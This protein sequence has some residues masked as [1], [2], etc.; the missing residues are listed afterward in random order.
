APY[1][2]GIRSGETDTTMTTNYYWLNNKSLY[3]GDNNRGYVYTIPAGHKKFILSIANVTR[4]DSNNVTS[5]Q[6]SISF[7]ELQAAGLEIWYSP[8]PEQT[9]P[10]PFNTGDKVKIDLSNAEWVNYGIKEYGTEPSY[11]PGLRIS[12]DIIFD[13]PYD[14]A[15]FYV[16]IN[17]PY[18]LGIRSGETDTAM[19]TNYY[20]LNNKYLVSGNHNRDYIYTIPAGHT[21]FILSIANVSRNVSGN[22]SSDE[23]ITLEELEAAGLEIW[24]VPCTHVYENGI[25]TGCGAEDPN[26]L[27]LDGLNVLCLGDSITAGQGLTTATRWTNVLAS[28]YDWTL[29][30]KSQGGISLSSYYYTSNGQTDVS[31][32]K[33]AEILKTMTVKPDV[34]IVWGGHNDISYRY[35]PLGTWNDETTDS[36]KGA[37]KYI[38]ELAHEYAPDATLFVLTPLWFNEKPYTL[39][40]PENTSDT[41]LMF[42]DAIYEGAEKYGWIPINMDLCGVTAF[43]KSDFLLDNVHPNAA[44]TELIVE[45]LSTELASYGENSKKDTIL[46]NKS[47]VSMKTGESTTLKGVLSPQSGYS[48]PAFTWNSSNPSVATIDANGKITA[49]AHGNTII[50]ATTSDGTSATVSVTVDRD[51]H[52][53]ENGIC[54]GCGEA[55][56]SL[57]GKAISILGDSISTFGGVSN[58]ANSNST[59]GGNA[60]YYSGQGGITRTDTWWQ[61]VIDVLDM[62]LLVNNSWSGSCVFQP[63]KGEASVGYTDRCV[64]LHNDYT[65]EEPDVIL[66]FLGTNDYKNHS[67]TIGAEVDVD[68]NAIITD[69]GDGTYTYATATTTC[70]AY[71]IMLHK[72]SVRYPDADIYCMSLLPRKGGPA[73]LT[74]F[75]QDIAVMAERFGCSFVDL[76]HC[77]ITPDAESM[78]KYMYDGSVHPNAEGMDLMSQA[79]VSALTGKNT[80]IR[81]VE[82]VLTNVA[83]DN[84]EH[85]CIDGESFSTKL[86]SINPKEKLSVTIT[87]GGEDITAS[88]YDNGNIFIENVTGDVKA[89]ASAERGDITFRWDYSKGELVNT[90]N[91]EYAA[92]ALVKQR[93][94]ANNGVFE[95]TYYRTQ[96]TVKLLHDKPWTLEW[97]GSGSGGFMLS[98]ATSAASS[99]VYFRRHTIGYLHV[100]GMYDGSKYNHYGVKPGDHG[101]DVKAVHTYRME[102]RINADGTNMV[103]LFVDGVEIGAMNNYYVGYV[104]QGTTDNWISG[105]DFCINYIG[106]STHPLDA[107]SMEYL[108]IWENGHTHTYTSAVT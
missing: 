69:K 22:I 38:A 72:M 106:T 59:I 71:A 62:E 76:E 25:C 92:N 94:S 7:L 11:N 79:V 41:N 33:K 68:Y 8:T 48:T 21:K 36:F 26:G 30:N 57:E 75:N 84:N 100:F 46:F 43:T 28:K 65:G 90:V 55:A 70:E 101:I 19:T 107:Y 12:T 61:Q 81:D 37:L 17:A 60:V 108:Q 34:I 18:E 99:T 78:G 32:A 40:V 53:Y 29:T 31:I 77:G 86:T 93:G 58:N 52:T 47:D 82:M 44:G 5:T 16:K 10:C 73:K 105:K 3:S 24:Y 64:N 50:T 88:A 27:P 35:S 85:A 98:D 45:F 104:S 14:G 67:D 103:Y 23:K 56:P 74:K 97:R 80:I 15:T 102:N 91:G 4:N 39:K 89:V 96:H 63:R 87:M 49:V 42:V 95:D 54:T 1:E 9:P 2:M 20:W 83:S 13:V 51:D 66:V 6:N